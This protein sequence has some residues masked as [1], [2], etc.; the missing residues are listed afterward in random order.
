VPYAV[1]PARPHDLGEALDL[2]RRAEL[3][4]NGVARGFGHY[5]VVRDDAKVVGLCG[6]EVHGDDGLLRSLVVDQH[7]RGEG[8]GSLL[9]DG[10]VALAARIGLRAVYLLTATARDYFARRG[11]SDCAREDAPAGIRDSWEFA[12]GCPATSAFMKRSVAS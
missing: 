4:D 5:L 11:F 8:L 3:P 6:L 12:V 7:Y 1:E 2:L 10:V 9:V